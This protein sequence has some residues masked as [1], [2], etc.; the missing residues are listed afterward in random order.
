M[1]IK[2]GIFYSIYIQISELQDAVNGKETEAAELRNQIDDLHYE[3]S[4]IQSRNE[5]LENHLAEAYEK[6]K[7]LQ[8]LVSVEDKEKDQ[9]AVI[10]PQERLSNVSQK[11]VRECKNVFSR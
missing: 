10:K 2:Q 1:N 9:T 5:K 7:L 8:Q 4:K 6:V 11:R 3:I